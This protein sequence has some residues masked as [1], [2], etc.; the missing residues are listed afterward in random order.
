[1][2]DLLARIERE[3]RLGELSVTV[4]LNVAIQIDVDG[5]F[6]AHSLRDNA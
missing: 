1:M 6:R 2:Q 3:S 4:H 5:D